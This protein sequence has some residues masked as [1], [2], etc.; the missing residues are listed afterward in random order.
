MIYS[1][2]L[3]FS[4]DGKRG[5]EGGKRQD[6]PKFSL[7]KASNKALT[8][9]LQRANKKLCFSSFFPVN[10]R[11]Q[12]LVN[13]LCH[14]DLDPQI[15]SEIF[16][17]IHK[18]SVLIQSLSFCW[19][20]WLRRWITRTNSWFWKLFIFSELSVIRSGFGD[21]FCPKDSIASWPWYVVGCEAA[22]LYQSWSKLNS[23]RLLAA[24]PA[25]YAALDLLTG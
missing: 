6:L 16:E 21:K 7:M 24:L 2:L 23:A 5:G 22:R 1:I 10:F 15:I 8:N 9:T 18:Y 4:V 25:Q 12:Y 14:L 20:S 3:S 19:F 11:W 17:L 13:G